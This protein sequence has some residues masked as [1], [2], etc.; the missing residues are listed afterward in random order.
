M[1]TKEESLERLESFKSL[2]INWSGY[3]ALGFDE[4]L[5][6]K[7]QEIIKTISVMPYVFPTGRNS[8]QFE[9]EKTN[10]DYLEFEIYEDKIECLLIINESPE[11]FTLLPSEIEEKIINFYKLCLQN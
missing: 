7:A 2:E 9:F 8:I 6:T 10:G 11:S 1:P 3:G 4:S 5:I